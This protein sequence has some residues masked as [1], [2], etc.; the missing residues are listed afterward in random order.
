M[1]VFLEEMVVLNDGMVFS[2]VLIRN[3][4][5]SNEKKEMTFI[6]SLKNLA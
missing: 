3:E 4:G 6:F 5:F 1:V 2:Q